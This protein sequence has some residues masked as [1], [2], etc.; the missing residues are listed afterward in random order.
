[1]NWEEEAQACVW[2]ITGCL[3]AIIGHLLPPTLLSSII[4]G[5]GGLV[6]GLNTGKV[7]RL[8]RRR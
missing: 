7:L 4:A 5:L 1:M 2:G 8:G 3:V 6:A